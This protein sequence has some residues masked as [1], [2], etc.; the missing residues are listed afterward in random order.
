MEVSDRSPLA[1]GG[2]GDEVKVDVCWGQMVG[3]CNVRLCFWLRVDVGL[4]SASCHMGASTQGMPGRVN[5]DIPSELVP[6]AVD[7]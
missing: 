7:Q 1:R 4:C 5:A 2:V 3:S 6:V